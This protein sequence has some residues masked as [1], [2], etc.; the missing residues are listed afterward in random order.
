MNATKTL[1][2][3]AQHFAE[4]AEED[5]EL[6]VFYRGAAHGCRTA[7]VLLS[8]GGVEDLRTASEVLPVVV[9]GRR[10]APGATPGYLRCGQC[11]NEYKGEQG[12]RVHL[13]RSATCH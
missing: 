13:A 8:P 9:R 4:L 7:K 11:G 3:L 5:P 6:E 1:A 10:T 12:M 2:F